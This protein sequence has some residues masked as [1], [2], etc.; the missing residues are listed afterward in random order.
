M[1]DIT[2]SSGDKA[3]NLHFKEELLVI[4]RS[5][6]LFLSI[7]TVPAGNFMSCLYVSLAWNFFLLLLLVPAA[8]PGTGATP[9]RTGV[10]TL[11][12]P[13]RR[14]QKLGKNSRAD[15]EFKVTPGGLS[16]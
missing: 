14:P 12:S 9:G 13:R 5:W 6:S 11:W 15:S 4:L 3:R 7:S 16:E 8:G 1:S 10:S 2:G